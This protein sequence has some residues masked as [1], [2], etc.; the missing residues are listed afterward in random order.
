MLGGI[1][2]AGNDFVEPDTGI[3]IDKIDESIL[4][5][6][7]INHRGLDGRP[8]ATPDQLERI[9]ADLLPVSVWRG[10]SP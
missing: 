9:A 3:V 5:L 8:H 7:R 4:G 1:T 10:G 2:P 6:L